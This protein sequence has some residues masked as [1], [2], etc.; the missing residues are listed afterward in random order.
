MAELYF[1]EDWAELRA[2]LVAWVQGVVDAGVSVVWGRQGVP[3]PPR[4]YVTLRPL[5]LPVEEGQ[6]DRMQLDG[7]V[8]AVVEVLDDTIYSATINGTVCSYTS[9]AT[10]TEAEISAGLLAAIEAQAIAGVTVEALLG[11]VR[12]IGAETI[13]TDTDLL[14]LKVART[15][16]LDGTS[17]FQV[18]VY[19]RDSQDTP[20]AATIAGALTAS[21]ESEDVLETLGTAWAVVSREAQRNGDAARPGTWEDRAGFD[22]R[23]RCRVRR[24]ELGDWIEH[25]DLDTG[26]VGVLTP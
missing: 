18:D 8:V 12:V 9:D 11:G 4:P 10:A 23:L 2:A 26:I 25:A 15:I 6:G 22:L 14:A 3:S 5:T 21:L 13:E 17:T 16:E 19:G 1:P 20:E 24:L 7:F